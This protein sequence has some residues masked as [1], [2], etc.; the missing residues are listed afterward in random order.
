[1]TCG[2]KTDVTKSNER[3][4]VVQ[5]RLFLK[6]FSRTLPASVSRS[7]TDPLEDALDARDAT[8]GEP[9]GDPAF[10]DVDIRLSKSNKGVLSSVPCSWVGLTPGEG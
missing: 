9:G 5:V 8:D 1:M 6:A 2:N 10:E 7:K 4:V 3:D